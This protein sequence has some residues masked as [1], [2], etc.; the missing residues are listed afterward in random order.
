MNKH[1]LFWG[2]NIAMWVE[3]I[4]NLLISGNQINTI[5]NTEI[6]QLENLDKF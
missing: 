5:S 3:V 6:K 4:T 2:V 1:L